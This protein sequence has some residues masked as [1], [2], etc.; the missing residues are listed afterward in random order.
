MASV[1]DRCREY[2]CDD[3]FASP[4]ADTGWYD[5][6][7]AYWYIEPSS[8]VYEDVESSLLVIGGPG[9]DGIRWGYRKGHEGI[10]AFYPIEREL[11][12]IA[13]SATDLHSGYA[14]GRIT[15]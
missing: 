1:P 3:Y 4:L 9:V 12:R 5:D 13:A 2:A 10:W 8:R 6:A 11:V 7:G 15:V 14:S